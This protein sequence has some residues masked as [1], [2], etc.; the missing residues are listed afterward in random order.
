MRDASI[1]LR[2]LPEQR[3]LFDHAA[4]LMGENRTDLMLEVACERAKAI[5]ADQVF[6]SLNENRFWLF[7]E[8]LDAPQGANRGLERLMAV[9]PLWDTGKG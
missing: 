9:K 1:N 2:E 3:D 7:T 8:L 6:F 4:N 5:V